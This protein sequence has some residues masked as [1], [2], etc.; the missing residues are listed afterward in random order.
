[1]ASGAEGA[2]ST[3]RWQAAEEGARQRGRPVRRE[4]YV[5]AEQ[6]ERRFAE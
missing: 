3:H 2:A 4:C 1:M 6:A 5:G